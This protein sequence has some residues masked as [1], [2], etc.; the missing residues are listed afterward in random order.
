M[1]TREDNREGLLTKD[2][3]KIFR[4][5]V[6]LG[7]VPNEINFPEEIRKGMLE[8]GQRSEEVG[9][10]EVSGVGYIDSKDEPKWA[11]V[12]SGPDQNNVLI[13]IVDLAGPWNRRDIYAYNFALKII[14]L[15]NKL[16]YE[17]FILLPEE[18]LPGNLELGSKSTLRKGKG[19]M[20]DF[21]FHPSGNA[22]SVGDFV[23]V[24]FGNYPGKGVVF[25][26]QVNYFVKTT[27]T[28]QPEKQGGDLGELETVE[29]QMYQ[30]LEEFAS[31][32]GLREQDVRI[33]FLIHKCHELGVAMFTGKIT[34]PVKRI[35]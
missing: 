15:S 10:K 27:N 3:E 28:R 13:N 24:I 8:L 26:D 6:R 30:E 16:G 32:R 7:E 17:T 19:I 5:F 35:A 1:D 25:G 4:E 20:A 12:S 21:H 29:K 34:E 22:A 18:R 2:S 33:P 31:E 14:G 23:R 11:N 9:R